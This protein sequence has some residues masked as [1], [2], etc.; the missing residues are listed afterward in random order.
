MTDSRAGADQ[1][2]WAI[3]TNTPQS[4]RIW[5]YWPGGTDN[6]PSDRERIWC[7]FGYR[8]LPRAP[9][10]GAHFWSERCVIWLAKRGSG[11]S[12]IGAGLPILD[13]AHEVAQAMTPECRVAY[14]DSDKSG[15]LRG[16]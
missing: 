7:W 2:S 9:G 3:D 12:S 10:R 11:N 15:R 13:N 5:N 6:Y 14:V 8:T 16:G 1:Q 4:A